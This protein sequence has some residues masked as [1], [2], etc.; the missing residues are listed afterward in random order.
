SDRAKWMRGAYGAMSHWLFQP[1]GTGKVEGTESQLA[2]QWNDKVNAF[3][4]NRLAEQLAEAGAKWFILTI[5]QNSGFYCAPNAAYDR[6]VGNAVSH[7]SSRDLFADLA[8]ALKRRGIR[9]MAYLPSGAPEIDADACAA[10]KWQNG[11]FKGDDGR[12]L[13]IDGIRA[14]KPNHRLADFQQ[15]WEEV[16]ST[17]AKQWGSLCSGWWI[18][19]VYFA[20]QMYRFEA[21][22]NFHTLAAALRAGN[23]DAAL[24]FNSGIARVDHLEMTSDEEDFSA[25]EL[26]SYLYTPFGRNLSWKDTPNAMVGESQLH[27]LNFLGTNWGQGERPRFPDD[28]TLAWSRYITANGAGLTWDVP[29]SETGAIPQAFIE[30]MSQI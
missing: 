29:T 25:G 11:Y 16:V 24:C 19:G 21:E 1:V 14:R 10:L 4:V 7:C 2:A 3:D 12:P 5:G 6:L 23:P 20:D 18:D 28:L 13:T 22:P 27:L 26:N 17:W 9:T 30:V 8:E 15:M